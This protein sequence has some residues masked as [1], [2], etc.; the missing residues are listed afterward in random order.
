VA[1]ECLAEPINEDPTPLF[2]EQ[3]Y[4]ERICQQTGLV[5]REE[6]RHCDTC[7]IP[8]MVL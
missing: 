3:D 7:D 4:S 6:K 2:D 1:A 5:C 8:E